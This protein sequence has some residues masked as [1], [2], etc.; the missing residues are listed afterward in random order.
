[1]DLSNLDIADDVEQTEKDTLGGYQPKDSDI[2]QAKIKQAYIDVSSG[3]AR[4]VH[5]E[6]EF[7]DAT[8]MR[9]NIYIS[10]NKKNGQNSFYMREGKKVILPGAAQVKSLVELAV[11]IGATFK[12]MKNDEKTVMVRD[13]ATGN[14]VQVAKVVLLDM[15]GKDIVVGITAEQVNKRV[16]DDLGNYVDSAESMVINE[17]DKFFQA[18]SNKTLTEVK[19]KT[20]ADFIQ[21]WIT[22][23]RGIT[24]DKRTIKGD[25]SGSTGAATAAASAGTDDIFPDET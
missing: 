1:M 3:G 10:T 8:T 18:G 4:F 12:S 20:S 25:T 16:K 21:K 15:L 11:G 2:Y 19:G 22:K 13:P 5:L 9:K 7:K 14:D 24:A 6:L 23:N 17:F